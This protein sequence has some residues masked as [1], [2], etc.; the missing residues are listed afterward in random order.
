MSWTG[1]C[2]N[3]NDSNTLVGEARGVVPF[4]KIEDGAGNLDRPEGFGTSGPSRGPTA[5]TG[6]R[7]LELGS[8]LSSVLNAWEYFKQ[9]QQNIG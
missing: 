9:E 8:Q 5:A 4:A 1:P 2:A 3:N 6:M 7:G